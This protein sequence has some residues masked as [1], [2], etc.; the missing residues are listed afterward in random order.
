MS[1]IYFKWKKVNKTLFS[2]VFVD[3]TPRPLAFPGFLSSTS[4]RTE[5]FLPLAFSCYTVPRV[6]PMADSRRARSPMAPTPLR[7]VN[8][9]DHS[10]I[11]NKCSDCFNRKQNI[12]VFLFNL[13][14]IR[15]M[16]HQ[17]FSLLPN[18][19]KK[20]ISLWL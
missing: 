7:S 11:V 15:R 13:W 6:T 12:F 17:Y 8:V 14:C 16:E 4:Y 1:T 5:A 20:S 9:R 18:G 2:M 3:S 10:V 19:S